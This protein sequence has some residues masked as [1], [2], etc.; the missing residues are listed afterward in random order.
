VVE[1]ARSILKTLEG[2]SGAARGVPRAMAP[3]SGEA[4]QL[5][6]FQRAPAAGISGDGAGDRDADADLAAEIVAALREVD[7]DDLSPRAA[8]DLV[9]T[10]RKKLTPPS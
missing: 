10:L 7:P 4:P 6:L 3:G 2:D 8:L 9:A 1:R 5:G